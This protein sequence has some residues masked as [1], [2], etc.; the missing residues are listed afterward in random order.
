MRTLLRERLLTAAAELTCADGWAS[1]TMG[2][3][4]ARVGVSRQ[5]VYKELGSKPELA[6]ALMLRETDGF[7]AGVAQT[8][9]GYPGDPVEGVTAAFQY[10]LEAARDNP[11]LKS[12]LAGGQG[13]GDD[14]LPLLTTQSDPVLARSV[15]AVAPVLVRLYPEVELSDAEWA[16]AVE[17]FVRLLLSHLV[18]PAMSIPHATEQMRWVIGRMLRA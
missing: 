5:T 4:A 14:L 9:S 6:E 11:L 18:Q 8:L 3:V 2:K 12:V 16:M 15:G 17:A 7:A 10:T 13:G 1:V